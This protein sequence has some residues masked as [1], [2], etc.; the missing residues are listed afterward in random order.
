MNERILPQDALHFAHEAMN[1]TFGLWLRGVDATAAPGIAKM[2]YELVD[3]I[4]SRLSRYIDNSEVSQINAL[5]AGETLYLSEECHQCLLLALDAYTRTAGLFDITLGAGIQHLKAGEKGPMPPVIGQLIIHP[6]VPAITCVAPGRQIDLGGIAKGFTLDL[7]KYFL[8][9]WEVED[10]LITAGASS[11]LAI[12]SGQWPVELSGSSHSLEIG[13]CDQSLSAS[14]MII[15]GSHIV[16]PAGM[17][18]MPVVPCSHVWV[19]ATSAAVAE[20]WSTALM[21]IA[22]DEIPSF[23]VGN[24][25]VLSVHV[26]IAGAL[27]KIWPLHEL[28]I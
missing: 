12:G 17:D 8:L 4:E 19:T 23:I 22:A 26:E 2:C 1:T 20:I 10:A 27:K 25:D 21:L 9:E 28:S 18:A 15:Q 16:H 11:M 6:D 13:L 24:D 14:G 7:L 3:S 5:S